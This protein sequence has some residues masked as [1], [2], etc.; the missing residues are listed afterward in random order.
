MEQKEE[1]KLATFAGGC[2]WCMT[3]PFEELPGV[4]KVVSGIPAE[5]TISYLSGSMRRE[6]RTP[7]SSTDHLLP[8]DHLLPGSSGS[9]LAA[10]RSH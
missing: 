9:I 10:D 7:G 4:T 8:Q 2:F 1:T 6:Y 5:L 3:A